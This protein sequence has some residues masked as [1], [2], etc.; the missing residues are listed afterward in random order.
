VAEAVPAAAGILIDA[1]CRVA[2]LAAALEA[3][4]ARPWD[5]GAIRAHAARHD[6]QEVARR[7]YTTWCRA[8]GRD[9]A[10]A[11]RGAEFAGIIR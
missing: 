7:V 2:D 10:V 1:P 6:W 11:P 3:A 5:E 4:L 8:V 9:D